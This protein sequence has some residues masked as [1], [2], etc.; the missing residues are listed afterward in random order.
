MKKAYLA[1]SYSNRSKLNKEVAQLRKSLE[2]NNVE[3]FVFVDEYHFGESQEK[4]MMKVAF[5][6]IDQSDFLIAEVTKK[7]IGVGI[8]VGYAHA[9]EIPVIYLKR[10]EANYSS[11][12][13]GCSDFIIEYKN[14]L[15]LVEKIEHFLNEDTLLKKT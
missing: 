11:T 3:L 6:E 1:I 13:G 8:E 2:R 5:E 9:K 10:K 7:A 12:V 14:E 4:E 15:D